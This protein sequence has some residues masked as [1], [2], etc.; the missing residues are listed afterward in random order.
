VLLLS[1]LLLLLRLRLLLIVLRLI[2]LRLLLRGLRLVTVAGIF[3][4]ACRDASARNYRFDGST[5]FKLEGEAVT[6]RT[7][8]HPHLD[9]LAVSIE[10]GLITQGRLGVRFAF[11]YGSP[12]MQAADWKQTARHQ[13]VFIT[14]APNSVKLRRTLDADEYFVEVPWLSRAHFYSLLRQADLYMDTIGFSGFNSAMQA[15]ECGLPIVT[16]E[17]KFMRG[18]FASGILRALELPELVA[19]SDDAY[20][21]LIVRIASDKAMR[22]V[23]RDRLARRRSTVF[24]TVEPVHSLERFIEEICA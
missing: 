19:E 2:G 1:R 17:G 4:A 14:E 18:R 6:V 8:V 12:T 7:A 15:V 20:A 23:L 9:L 22:G 5:G 13:T 21:E 3:F 11:P 16:R 10:S 24:Y